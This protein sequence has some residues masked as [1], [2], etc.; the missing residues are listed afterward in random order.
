MKD[1]V[2]DVYGD[3]GIAEVLLLTVFKFSGRK[4]AGPCLKKRSRLVSG[5]GLKF[6]SRWPFRA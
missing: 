1:S 3:C 2:L 5:I 4:L 6:G